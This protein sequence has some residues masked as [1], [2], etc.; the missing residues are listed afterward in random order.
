MQNRGVWAVGGRCSARIWPGTAVR[1]AGSICACMVMLRC[2]DANA[3]ALQQPAGAARPPTVQAPQRATSPAGPQTTSTKQTQQTKKVVSK[4]SRKVTTPQGTLEHYKGVGPGS[5]NAYLLRYSEDF[6]YLASPSAAQDAPD[7]FNF[8]KYIPFDSSGDVYLTFN[9]EERLRLDSSSTKNL[10]VAATRT[11]K[12]V[13]GIGTNKHETDLLKSRTEIGMDLHVQKWFRF[14]VDG[15]NAQQTSQNNGKSVSAMQRNDF[16]LTNLFGEFITRPDGVAV[17]VRI[18]RQ[19]MQFGNSL[20]LSSL[21]VANVPTT[22]DGIRGYVDWGFGRVD[23]F[24][25]DTVN[26]SN[27]AFDDKDDQLNRYWGVYSSFDFPKFDFLGAQAATSLD[28]FYIGY[29][30]LPVANLG[31]GA[32]YDDV[33]YTGSAI[34]AA[35]FSGIRP[36]GEDLRH[37]LGLRYFGT[38]GKFDIDWQGA[39]Q[40]GSYGSYSVS[41][42]AYNTT[43]GYTFPGKWMPRFAIRADGATG[44][45]DNGTIHT[46][47]PMQSIN[48]YYEENAVLNPTNFKDISFRFRLQPTDQISLEV[49]DTTFWRWNVDDAVYSGTWNGGRGANVYAATAFNHESFIGTQPALI[50]NYAPIPHVVFSAIVADFIPGRALTLAGAKDTRY[51]NL[52][53]DLRF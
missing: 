43:T 11:A 1:V 2:A 41:A 27:E 15:I 7:I 47:N 32:Y 42:F 18:G 40:F 20:Q 23:A 3:Q 33:F 38:V 6:S 36:P 44:G 13:L 28:A 29:R 8:L 4:A 22:Y 14:Y 39:A 17:G 37:T 21:F 34:T 49:Y 26:F 35:P 48:T 50:I 12:G 52:Q 24:G 5:N 45:T 10:S 53:T 51:L 30:E 46:Y 16:V 19:E 31:R 9:G 25:F